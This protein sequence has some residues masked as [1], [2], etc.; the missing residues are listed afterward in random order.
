MTR[1]DPITQAPCCCE[2]CLDPEARSELISELLA[3]STETGDA[4]LS[5]VVRGALV[6][7]SARGVWALTA[8]PLMIGGVRALVPQR[9]DISSPEELRALLS[10]QEP[11]IPD[12]HDAGVL[13]E[14]A[15]A[16]AEPFEWT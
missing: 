8:R 16:L 9:S 5:W 7:S 13:D 14:L 15:A 3:E 1:T 11:W 12:E 2:Q 4:G 6:V 10:A